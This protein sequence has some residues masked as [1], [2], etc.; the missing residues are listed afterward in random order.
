V[1]ETAVSMIHD[2]IAAMPVTTDPDS[3]STLKATDEEDDRAIASVMSTDASDHSAAIRQLTASTRGALRL[4][5]LVQQNRLNPAVRQAVLTATAEHPQAEVRDLFERFLPVSLRQKRLGTSVNTADILAMSADAERGR[6]LFFR[7]GAA[8]CRGCH[9]VA[10]IGETLGPELTL[11]GKK[12][13]PRE[14]LVH[15]L[16]PSKLIDTK[17]VPWVLETKDGLV[18]TGLLVEKT[19][20][21]VLLKNAQNK[22]VRVASADVET[23]V[24]QQK[25]LMPE[26]LLRD[27][28][29]QQ[30]ADLLAYLCSLK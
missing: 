11:I 12:Y 14:M 26:L 21:H 24:S 30:A 20:E 16:E 19:A 23:L 28:T 1:D 2:W 15:L 13:P 10:G 25:S 22:E 17:F 6:Q 3:D 8:S 5:Q 9:R 29:A 27:L 4:S 7:E 18:H